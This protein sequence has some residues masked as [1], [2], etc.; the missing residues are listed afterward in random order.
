MSPNRGTTEAKVRPI[1]TIEKSIRSKT[2]YM[3]GYLGMAFLG[4]TVS[5]AEWDALFYGCAFV[6]PSVGFLVSLWYCRR[7]HFLRKELERAQTWI[8][9]GDTAPPPPLDQEG[10]GPNNPNKK[11]NTLSSFNQRQ[12]EKTR[13]QESA[14]KKLRFHTSNRRSILC[15]VNP[16]CGSHFE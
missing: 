15:I 9:R 7:R 2:K 1:E 6:Y 12:K 8:H 10:V 4:G 11:C 5:W 16:S 14:M 3:R 13:V